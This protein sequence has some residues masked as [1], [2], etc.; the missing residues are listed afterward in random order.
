MRS[1]IGLGVNLILNPRTPWNSALAFIETKYSAGDTRTLL[2]HNGV[3]YGWNGTH[4]PTIDPETVRSDLYYFL[5]SADCM[6]NGGTPLPFAPTSRRVTDVIDALKGAT[7]LTSSVHPP[8]WLS[9]VSTLSPMEIIACQNGLLHVPTR[10]LLAHTPDFF[11]LYALPY[12]YNPNAGGPREWLSFLSS[13][14]GND[15]EAIATLQEIMGYF[16]TCDT[17]QQKIFLLVGPKR[18]G[19]GTIAKVLTALLGRE[20]V[21]APTLAG[22]GTNFGLAPLIDKPL[23]II[24]DARLSGRADQQIIAERLLSI[25][26]EDSLTI[27]RKYLPAWTG[28]L[29]TR[30][31]ILTN[32][33]PRLADASGALASRFVTLVMTKSF[34][35]Q[36]DLGLASRLLAELP[37]IL[38]WTLEGRDRLEHRG[39]FIPPASSAEV[40][41]ELEDLG[42]PVGAFLRDC[43]EV[44]PGQS[45]EVDLLYEKWRSYSIIH[46]RDRPSTAQI[47]GRDL[48]AALPGLR[49]SQPRAGD[50]RQRVYVGVGLRK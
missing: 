7:N 23:A 39:Y 47:F 36:E 27:D 46:G 50:K 38:N 14:W 44:G 43:C 19:K 33:L 40:A 32:E 15:A 48:R 1:P 11:T 9:G 49:V 21:A 17:R 2:H 22:I 34:Y 31:L 37:S 45:V 35:E 28:R 42:S 18:S 25:S 29:P 26:G 16:L 6:M 41:R 24:A 30:I 8:A 4:Y 3:F 5:D 13:I 10:K 20:N 12:C